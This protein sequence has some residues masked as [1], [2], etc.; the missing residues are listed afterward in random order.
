MAY[1]IQPGGL[2]KFAMSMSG[3]PTL[4]AKSIEPGE[5]PALTTTLHQFSILRISVVQSRQGHRPQADFF[6]PLALAAGGRP[7]RISPAH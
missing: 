2:A 7:L 5:T 6:A 1:G 3:V 4:G